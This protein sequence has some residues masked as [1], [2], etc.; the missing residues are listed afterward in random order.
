MAYSRLFS[1][2]VQG[3]PSFGSLKEDECLEQKQQWFCKS[4]AKAAMVLQGG[5]SKQTYLVKI[6]ICV[7]VFQLGVGYKLRYVT[8]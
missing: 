3:F 2:A 4:R 6:H 7:K 1:E 8:W 5:K